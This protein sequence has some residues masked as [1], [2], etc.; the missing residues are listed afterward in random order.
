MME[1]LPESRMVFLVRDPRDVV[2]S[3]LHTSAARPNPK[4]KKTAREQPEEFV[5]EQALNYLRDVTLAKQ[6]Y[7]AH[8]GHKVL[9]RY[10]DLKTDTLVE[11]K[12]IYSALE[13]PVEEG[14]LKRAVEEHAWENIPEGKKGE[15]TVRRRGTSGVWRENLTPHQVEIVQSITAPILE[16]FY[17]WWGSAPRLS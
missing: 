9:V 5:R 1:A 16:E 13:M 17:D 11:M 10:E 14:E 3:A 15:G 6:A 4:R 12:R 8:R 7:Q 2:A